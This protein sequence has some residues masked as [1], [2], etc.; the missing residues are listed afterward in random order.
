MVAVSRS[1]S[2]GSRATSTP[3]GAVPPPVWGEEG[4]EGKGGRGGKRGI[5]GEKGEGEEGEEEEGE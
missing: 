1:S 3:S 5:G 2:L 4:G